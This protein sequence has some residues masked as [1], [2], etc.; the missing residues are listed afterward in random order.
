MINEVVSAAS[1][2]AAP[3]VAEHPIVAYAR[4][5][6]EAPEAAPIPTEAQRAEVV[7]VAGTPQPP[8]PPH[9]GAGVCSGAGDGGES[10][11]MAAAEERARRWGERAVALYAR[12]RAALGEMGTVAP[13][14]QYGTLDGCRNVWVVKPAFG[15][16]GVGVR[17]FSESVHCVLADQESLRVVQKYV[18]RPLLVRGYKFDIRCWVVVTEWS[19]PS[20]HAWFY[21]AD[22]LCR[23]CSDPFALD[24]LH[25]RYGHITN[26]AVQQ[27]R[28]RPSSA[29][30]SAS[31]ALGGSAL[32]GSAFGGGAFGGSTIG[33]LA[34]GSALGGGGRPARASSARPRRSLE[35]LSVAATA[36]QEERPLAG[37]LWGA[38]QL[39]EHLQES[40]GRHDVWAE[41]VLPQMRAV[42]AATLR[43]GAERA[44]DAPTGVHESFEL[45]GLDMVLDETLRPWLIEVNEAPNLQAH[46][47]ALKELILQ[48]MLTAA[49]EL[50]VDPEHRREPPE[51]VGGWHRL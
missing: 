9:S 18:E 40:T 50:L 41:A 42:A 24:Q 5:A 11:S 20:L 16:K 29:L 45:Y 23:F 38:Q 34:S 26:R 14:S 19:S 2:A 12:A 1:A 32:G 8:P 48:P 39:A 13:Q 27:E 43:R 51:R 4:A 28:T 10:C 22:V 7:R 44:A 17:L 46:G 30:A 33:G 3:A 21:D 15:S 49:V 37:A 6:M 47:S 31:C 25:N 36:E 35:A